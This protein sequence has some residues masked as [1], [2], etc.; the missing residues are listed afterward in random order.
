MTA[1]DSQLD[2]RRDLTAIRDIAAGVDRLR[3]LRLKLEAD[4]QMLQRGYFTPEEDDAARR[5]L[6]LYRNYRIALFDIIQRCSD[7]HERNNP[8]ERYFT[9][10]VGYGAAVLLYNWS[11]V[12][13]HSYEHHGIIRKKLNEPDLRFGIEDHLFETIY[14]SLTSTDN[15]RRLHDAGAFYEQHRLRI[16]RLIAGDPDG[17]WLLAEVQLQHQNI[18]RNWTEILTDRVLL[19]IKGWGWSARDEFADIAFRLQSM[20]ID[21]IGNLWFDRKP[22]IP[23]YQIKRLQQLMQPGDLIVVRPERKSSTILIPG[24]W[25]HMAFHHGG[26][27]ALSRD[28]LQDLEC[29]R[30]H[31]AA[32]TTPADEPVTTLEAL[33]PGVLLNPLSRTLGVD[34]TV[35]LRPRLSPA[36]LRQAV[37]NAFGQ[38]GK[39]YDFEVDFTRADRVVCT[40]VIYRS[41]N[42]LDGIHFELVKRLGRPTLSADDFLRQ[43]LAAEDRGQAYV[44]VI[45]LSHRDLARRRS[46]LYLG[47]D[48]A[49]RLRALTPAS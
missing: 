6:L 46:K 39:P 19:E 18:K 35:I 31:W 4:G 32:L 48:A 23:K 3:D 40:E 28:G 45:G 29:V 36:G 1:A 21:F 26:A 15:L 38:V 17:E 10:L 41:I 8:R 30:R 34:H 42:G 11:A 44:D 37:D 20:V 27:A 43:A 25:T 33:A 9:F 13:I 47:A 22:R 5:L 7:F 49:A 2:L 14:A 12:L 16:A 24:F